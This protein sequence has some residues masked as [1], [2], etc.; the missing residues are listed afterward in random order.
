MRTF[1]P[2]TA[3]L[4]LVLVAGAGDGAAAPSSPQTTTT[5]ENGLEVTLHPLS[6]GEK[7]ALV[8]VYDLGEDHDPEGKSGLAHLVEHC[9]VTSAAGQAKQRTAEAFMARYPQAWN[10]Q[11][12]ARYTVIALLFP[13]EKL[14]SEIEEAAARMGALEITQAD[15]DRE[16]PRMRLELASMFDSVSPLAAANRAAERARPSPAGARKGG[17]I[18]QIE[19]LTLAD[20]QAWHGKHYKPANARLVL[21]GPFEA[22]Q[23]EALV[24]QHFGPIAKGEAVTPRAA[25][26][27]PEAPLQEA[28]RRGGWVAK[29]WR[30]PACDG[31]DYAPFLIL[32]RRLMM[33][34]MRRGATADEPM[35][36]FA[37]LD[38]PEVLTIT[39]RILPDESSAE[40]A[41]RIDAWLDDL[42]GEPLGTREG[43]VTA[44]D[45]GWLLG[46]T[47]IPQAN[48]ARNPY[49]VAFGIARRAQLGLD[50]EVLAAALASV[51]R[52]AFDALKKRVFGEG[53]GATAAVVHGQ[54]GR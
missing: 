20:V 32:A 17:V 44:R 30:A 42:S 1:C 8:I 13:K 2:S 39:T 22:E 6:T 24:A 35:P 36:Q 49:P 7:I 41:A 50:P 54:G 29:A 43:R 3:F 45:F 46:T 51:D 52:A 33:R 12:G 11:T 14:E 26:P 31:Q 27:T 53:R 21:L 38:R 4:F 47:E 18:A 5:L 19:T 40:A 48:V 28:G 34:A 10:A 37:P 23:G 9:Y 15:L 25:G 16:V